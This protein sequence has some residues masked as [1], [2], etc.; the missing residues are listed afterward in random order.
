MSK[1]SNPPVYNVL[2]FL[3]MYVCSQQVAYF[4]TPIVDP[5]VVF[6]IEVVGYQTAK[7]PLPNDD[8]APKQRSLGWSL[9]RPFVAGTQMKDVADGNPETKK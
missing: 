4:H 1:R 3:F 8:V 6:A 7:N 5:N 2:S 9:L